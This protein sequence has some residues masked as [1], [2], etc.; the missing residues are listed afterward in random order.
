MH[1]L[2]NTVH[3][4]KYYIP[5]DIENSLNGLEWY[6]QAHRWAVHVAK[7]SGY[8]LELVCAVT[9]VLSPGVSWEVNKR[10][11]WNILTAKDK[12]GVVVSTYGL[13]KR[14][15]IHMLETGDLT[16]L[17]GRKVSA[18]YHNIFD[19]ACKQHVTID[20]HAVR[21]CYGKSGLDMSADDIPP[22]RSAKRYNH[23]AELYKRLAEKYSLTP[24]QVQAIIWVEYRNKAGLN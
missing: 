2:P 20:R 24:N 22:P 21:A 6:T 10:D 7:V 17:K 13:N 14:K 8:Q 5:V 19:P 11:A 16:V 1:T 12:R 15:A 3:G 9:A 18:F 23:F 4:L